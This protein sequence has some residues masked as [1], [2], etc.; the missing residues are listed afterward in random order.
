[1]ETIHTY[2]INLER[3][4]PKRDM[5]ISQLH[6]YC[7][8]DVEFIKGIDGSTLSDTEKDTLSTQKFRQQYYYTP[9]ALGCALSHISI[10]NK[11]QL[12]NVDYALVLEDDAIL[13]HDLSIINDLISILKENQPVVILL[14]PYFRYKYNEYIKIGHNESKLFNKIRDAMMTSGYLININAARLLNDKLF[15]VN[16]LADNWNA[17]QKMGLKLYGVVPHLVSFP[18]STGEIGDSFKLKAKQNLKIR[19]RIIFG[20]LKYFLLLCYYKILGYYSS[21][22]LW[23][24]T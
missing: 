24:H 15:P 18:N 17:F 8:L 19:I 9:A 20:K 1:M 10:Y 6:N 22:K 12:N 4:I 2:I 23:E 5:M 21:K 14:T 7:Y 11:M 16:Y 13:F 3:D